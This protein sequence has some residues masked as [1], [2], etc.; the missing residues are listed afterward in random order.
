MYKTPALALICSHIVFSATTRS[1]S[2]SCMLVKL[3]LKSLIP[4]ENHI[5]E[6]FL[7]F[8]AFNVSFITKRDVPSLSY[9]DFTSILLLKSPLAILLACLEISD[10]LFV[11][12]RIAR[13]NLSSLDNNLTSD[14]KSPSDT[15]FACSIVAS[16]A[17]TTLAVE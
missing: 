1:L 16:I 6:S 14:E 17:D 2:K 12:E 5:S 10:N 7:Y 3:S 13:P 11:I 4:F 8:V 9:F 15:A